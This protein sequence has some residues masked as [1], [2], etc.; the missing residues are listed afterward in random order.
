[1]TLLG[2]IGFQI[3]VSF[4]ASA[5]T[6][7]FPGGTVTK[8]PS[9][10]L[11]RLQQNLRKVCVRGSGRGTCLP[12]EKAVLKPPLGKRIAGKACRL[13]ETMKPRAWVPQGMVVFPERKVV[14]FC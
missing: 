2:F 5:A 8:F 4:Q 13:E 1:M 11:P 9:R 7:S 14:W 6:V 10:F 12:E 3:K